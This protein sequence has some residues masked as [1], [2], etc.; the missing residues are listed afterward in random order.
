MSRIWDLLRYLITLIAIS[1][2]LDTPTF[3]EKGDPEKGKVLYDKKCAWCHG[4]KGGGDGPAAPFLNPPP[5]DFTAGIYKFK[6]S[7]FDEYFAFDEDIFRAI[8]D[9]LR[10]TSMPGWGDVLK[11]K[12]IWD[13][14]A[15]LK[16]LVEGYETPS[17]RVELN[18]RIKPSKDSIEKGKLLF[19]ERC[20]ECHGEEGKG[21]ATKILR[22]DWGFRTW[23]RN[24]TKGWTFRG[25]N[26]P[27]AIYTRISVGIPGTPM[28]SFADKGSKGFMTDEERWHVA[29]Y[30]ASLNDESK[31]V[32]EG[33]TVIKARAIDGDIPEKVDDPIWRGVEGINLP[34]VPQI[35]AKERF[36]TPTNDI[37]SVKALYNDREIAFLLEWDDRTKSIPGDEKALE[38]V[39]GELYEDAVA[40]QFPVKIPEGMEKPYF[41]HGDG[42]NPVNIWLWK[43]GTNESPQTIRLIDSKGFDNNT[44]RESKEFKATGEYNNGTWR[45][46]IKRQL[47]TGDEKDIQFEVGRFIPIAF[48]NWDGSNGEVGS[49]H[50]LTTWYWLLLEPP[51]GMK[52]YVIPLVSVLLIVGL[53][54][55][56]ARS[57]K[58]EFE[59][60]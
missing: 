15:Y 10:G 16:T 4:W 34:L 43:S 56:L 38:L 27:E 18:G 20:V 44:V 31:R 28:P 36:F 19:K 11:D 32:R 47:T 39:E 52:V 26:Q 58:K 42:S 14:I 45:V 40:I 37:I 25:G 55:Y 12:D 13:I 3:A 50:T 33:E 51:A 60:R 24:L 17:K 2:L 53:E 21:V 30:V 57:F 59:G 1:L 46:I 35:I 23:P 5:R 29:N 8:K 6:S 7:T 54:V 48:A 22:D 9:G 41:G 49:K